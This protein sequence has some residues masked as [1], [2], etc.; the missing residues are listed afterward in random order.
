MLLTQQSKPQVAKLLALLGFVCS[1]WTRELSYANTKYK[2]VFVLSSP[3]ALKPPMP[4]CVPV[5][6]LSKELG[7]LFVCCLLFKW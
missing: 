4:T 1:S 5:G 3:F 6:N 7:Q 2:F